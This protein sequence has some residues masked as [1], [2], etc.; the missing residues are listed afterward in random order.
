MH[1]QQN[2]KTF[3]VCN[4]ENYFVIDEVEVTSQM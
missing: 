3:H 1:G 4:Y 2:I